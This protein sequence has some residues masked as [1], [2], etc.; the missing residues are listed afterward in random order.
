MTTKQK[1]E[2]ALKEVL[3]TK[4]QNQPKFENKAITDK[5]ANLK[6]KLEQE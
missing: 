5:E 2:K 4:P 1:L 6:F 3:L